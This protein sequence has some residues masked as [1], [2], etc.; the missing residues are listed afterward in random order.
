[1]AADVNTMVSDYNGV[2][3]YVCLW[4][5]GGGAGEWSGGMCTRNASLYCGRTMSHNVNDIQFK[6]ETSDSE[7]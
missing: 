6:Y 7:T 1:M 5:K 4:G 3:R 2:V